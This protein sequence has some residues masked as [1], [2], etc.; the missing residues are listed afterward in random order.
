M[1]ALSGLPQAPGV[2]RFR[3]AGGRVLYVGRATQLRSRVRSYWGD[4]H[5]RRHL[6]RMVPQIARV[7]AVECDSVHEAA[8]LERNLLQRTKPRWNRIR[9]GLEVPVGI[10]VTPD[11]LKVVHLHSP[12]D[13]DFGP[14]LGGAQARLAVSGLERVFPL[15]YTAERL[16][17]G[18]RDLARMRGVSVVD[19]PAFHT[20]ITAVLSRDQEHS[21]SVREQLALLR[22]RAAANLA[23]ELAGRIQ[24]ELEAVDWIVAEQKMTR[25]AAAEPDHDV[26]GWADGLLVRFRVR[27]GRVD[28]WEQRAATQATARARVDLTPPEWAAFAARTAELARRLAP[29]A[30]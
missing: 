5:G 12:S 6:R 2:Y 15:R 8:W 14:Y 28:G 26:Y 9:G 17:G 13:A 1:L 7:E 22:D 10:R 23:F 24:Q 27:N 30:L 11:G 4:L 21:L 3:D 29:E 16:D 25:L 18:L 20:A 19:R